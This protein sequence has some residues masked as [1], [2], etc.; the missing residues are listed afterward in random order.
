MCCL[1]DKLN[2]FKKLESNGPASSMELAKLADMG[3][4][5][6]RLYAMIT[7]F[8]FLFFVNKYVRA[9]IDMSYYIIYLSFIISYFYLKITRVG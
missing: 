5:Y 4:R 3:E 2:L 6:S 8:L 1:D 9:K 7:E